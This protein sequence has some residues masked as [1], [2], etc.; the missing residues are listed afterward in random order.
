MEPK[1]LSKATALKIVA[2]VCAFVGMQIVT[3]SGAAWSALGLLFDG[4]K[5]LGFKVPGG[6]EVVGSYAQTL[7]VVPGVKTPFST[8]M[9]QPDTELTPDELAELVTHEG[10]HGWQSNHDAAWGV[11]Y[12]QHREYRAGTA[13][14]PAFA[15]ALALRWARTNEIP[16]SLDGFLSVMRE[17]YDA[18]DHAQVG[19]DVIEL[20]AT[21]IAHGVIRNPVARVAIATLYREQPDAIHP[22]SLRLMKANCP[23]ALVV[24]S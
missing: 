20:T 24:P 23:A 10:T 2:A 18:Q 15:G 3:K 7:P 22:E 17:A 14:G 16:A 4:L 13:E 5:F 11:K 8:V 9:L 21:E 19:H 12:L 6:A 1:P